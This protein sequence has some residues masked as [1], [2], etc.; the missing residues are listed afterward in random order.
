MIALCIEASHSRG[1][2]HLFRAVNLG[3]FLRSV[4][5]PFVIVALADRAA[6]D[7]LTQHALP[8]ET[9]APD[10]ATPWEAE[11]IERY[12]I[13]TWV[14]DRLDTDRPHAERVKGCGL[15]LATFDD[16]GTGAELADLHFA[17]LAVEGGEL[18]RGGRVLTGPEYLVLNPEIDRYKRVRTGIASILVTLGGSDT[19]G[20]TPKVV[21]LLKEMDL[22]ATVI[23][24]PS[25]AHQA[26]LAAVIDSRF[27]L[28]SGVESLVAEFARHDLAITGGGVT[29]FEAGA[30]G[31]PSVVIANE[32]HE[33]E[34]GRYLQKAGTS[35]FAGHHAGL[36][37]LALPAAGELEGMS[38]RGMALFSTAGAANVYRELT[39]G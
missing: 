13:T 2:G 12:R 8:F 39:R 18:L 4:G 36:A 25:F 21:R 27:T 7:I 31:L 32:P 24:G 16:R 15:T 28:K 26:E 20:V 29:P 3:R 35:L 9:V 6:C 14:N 33:M 10:P 30:S 11:L 17:P 34:I 23:T 5:E 1:L 19:Y 38:R 37:G 22:A